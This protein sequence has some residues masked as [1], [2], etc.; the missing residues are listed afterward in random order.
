MGLELRHL[1]LLLAVS[2][3]GARDG[4]LPRGR[5]EWPR[6]GHGVQHLLSERLERRRLPPYLTDFV[7]S[8]ARASSPAVAALRRS[9]T[10]G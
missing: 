4:R 9:G 1:K 7:R 10:H 3:D 6:S 2:E 5:S 8:L